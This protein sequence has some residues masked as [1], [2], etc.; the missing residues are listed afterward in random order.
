ME[1]VKFVRRKTTSVTYFGSE[2]MYS[3]RVW[4]KMYLR[5]GNIF[6]KS[7]ITT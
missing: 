2:M 7:K 4:E 6:I 1:D 3:N 5:Q